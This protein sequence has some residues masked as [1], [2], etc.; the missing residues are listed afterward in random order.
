[1]II[2]LSSRSYNRSYSRAIHKD[3]SLPLDLM[4]TVTTNNAVAKTLY[5]SLKQEV[6][7]QLVI[8]TSKELQGE[9][10]EVHKEPGDKDGIRKLLVT[11]SGDVVGKHIIY[12]EEVELRT[13]KD[14]L[15]KSI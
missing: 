1:M 2:S 10:G 6:V 4:F 11:L 13:L 8:Q 9:S 12:G 5:P 15:E 3:K 14:Q 7:L